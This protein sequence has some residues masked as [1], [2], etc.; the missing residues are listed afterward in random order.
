MKDP[1]VIFKDYEEQSGDWPKVGC[2]GIAGAVVDNAV[3]KHANMDHWP[4]TDGSAIAKGFKLD[5]FT[6]IND[7]NAAGQ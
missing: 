3:Q 2:V 7:F 6:L 5:E 1:N 4:P